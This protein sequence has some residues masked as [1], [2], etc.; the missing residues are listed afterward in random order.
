MAG[1]EYDG[2]MVRK[3][4]KK[5]LKI[6]TRTLLVGLVLG[7]ILGFGLGLKYEKLVFEKV[8]DGDTF[9]VRNLRNGEDWKVRLWGVDAP[10]TKQCYFK[11][12]T[13]VLER[14]LAGKKLRYR[15]YGYDGYGRILAEVY[16]NGKNVEET[17]V[18]TGAV[19]AYGATEVHDELRPSAEYTANLKKIEE[20]ARVKKL[21]M[22]SDACLKK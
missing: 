8:V 13:E 6:P 1:D 10:D 5:S 7:W 14:E 11:E 3:G 15:R 9:W 19:R 16:V 22:W 17:L 2:S 12:A 18:A 4:R 20:M 21:G